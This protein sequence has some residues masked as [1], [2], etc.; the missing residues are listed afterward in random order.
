LS[1]IL[2]IDYVHQTINKRYVAITHVNNDNDNN[3]SSLD[4][5]EFKTGRQFHLSHSI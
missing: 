3:V 5:Y 2:L 1:I 4:T